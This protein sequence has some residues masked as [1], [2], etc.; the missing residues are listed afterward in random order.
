MTYT[1][2]IRANPAFVELIFRTTSAPGKISRYRLAAVLLV[3]WNHCT[4]KC[5]KSAIRVSHDWSKR[6][7]CPA[8]TFGHAQEGG[9]SKKKTC[10]GA[11]LI[12][13]GV[14]FSQDR[15]GYANRL[16]HRDKAGQFPNI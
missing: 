6:F 1:A 9:R 8:K 7:C 11:L 15:L 4:S 13:K 10:L 5:K 16:L 12:K 14:G 3:R 2:W